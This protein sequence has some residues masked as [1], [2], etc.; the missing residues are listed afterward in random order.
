M[1]T[2]LSCIQHALPT[3]LLGF[4]LERLLRVNLKP[5]G[6]QCYAAHTARQAALGMSSI[7]QPMPLH[8]D[9]DKE[10]LLQ[11]LCSALPSP[12][13]HA[14]SSPISRAPCTFWT[15]LKKH[16]LL[17]SASFL[18]TQG[19]EL[20]CTALSTNQ[21]L[22]PVQASSNPRSDTSVPISSG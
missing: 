22:I 2:W 4:D 17:R 7:S 16:K 19:A 21:P 1:M 14:L 15:S 3:P 9:R 11:P 8:R 12:T 10:G 6:E 18:S 20:I 5:F 13:A